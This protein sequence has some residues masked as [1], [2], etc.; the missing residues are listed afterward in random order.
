MY[1]KIEG[2]SANRSKDLNNKSLYS[3]FLEGAWNATSDFTVSLL[4]RG[5]MEF[6]RINENRSKRNMPIIANYD[7]IV[8]ETHKHLNE[9]SDIANDL[10]KGLVNACK[11]NCDNLRIGI[12]TLNYVFE[13]KGLN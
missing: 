8:F 6:D 12:N 7:Q 13:M 2:Y 11:E 9:N 10:T 5:R 1:K 4:W 3:P